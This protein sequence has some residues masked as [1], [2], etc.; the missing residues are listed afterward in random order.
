MGASTSCGSC[1][2]ERG[3]LVHECCTLSSASSQPLP[4]RRVAF[5]GLITSNRGRLEDR[6]T[7]DAKPIGFGTFSRVY[8]CTERQTGQKRAAK[9]VSR[10]IL[11]DDA[12]DEE[13]RIMQLLDHP[14]VVRLVETFEDRHQFCL[15]IE[16]CEGGELFDLVLDEGPLS[17]H[18]AGQLLCQMLRAVAY[19]HR[20]QV[21]HRDLKAENWLLVSKAASE[22][23]N[24]KLADFGFAKELK[25]G[26]MATT[27]VGTPYYVAP[28][29][30]EGCYDSKADIWS[31]GVILH[32]MLTGA[33]PFTGLSGE[34]LQ[35]V[36][37]RN[38][39]VQKLG[40][41]VSKLG[42]EV[43]EE[44]LR[45]D[46]DTRPAALEVMQHKWLKRHS[47]TLDTFQGRRA[48]KSLRRSSRENVRLVKVTLGVIAAQLSPEALEELDQTFTSMDSNG[49]GTLTAEELEHGLAAAGVHLHPGEAIEIVQ[50]LDVDGNGAV[51]YSEFLAATVQQAKSQREEACRKAFN[52][53]DIDGNGFI[54]RSELGKLLLSEGSLSTWNLDDSPTKGG[55][56]PEINAIY[57]ELDADRD[58][59]IDFAEFMAVMNGRD[60][61]GSRRA[62]GGG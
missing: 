24:L 19:L 62:A 58:G 56:H 15:V 42:K 31:L 52:V 9:V 35:Q 46:P 34:V 41:S 28:E 11:D 39:N 43:L 32:M 18:A 40:K 3:G 1:S 54:D 16:L 12:F 49:D 36:R 47:R 30:I 61:L 6:Y 38:V 22:I 55:H 37:K 2:V 33:P 5:G 60:K 4:S 27:K 23:S 13:V 17:E 26:E 7:V 45:R 21:M 44:L 53:F 25:P 59:K 51:D 29:V 20:M 57:D 10:K 50:Q 48:S 14:N 8:Q